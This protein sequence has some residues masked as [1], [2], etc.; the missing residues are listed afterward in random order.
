[1]IEQASPVWFWFF[2]SALR[3]LFREQLYVV[4]IKV[5]SFHLIFYVENGSGR[6]KRIV[7]RPR[8]SMSPSKTVRIAKQPSAVQSSEPSENEESEDESEEEHFPL[9]PNFK[10]SKPVEEVFNEAYFADNDP[11][12]EDSLAFFEREHN[13]NEL[14]RSSVTI[15]P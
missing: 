8:V 4:T 13:D 5:Y 14:V 2:L 6:L 7:T 9:P 12:I 15:N 1:M 10:L 11:R 3:N